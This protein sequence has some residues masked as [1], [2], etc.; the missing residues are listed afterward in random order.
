M[1]HIMKGILVNIILLR[2]HSFH[3]FN[4]TDDGNNLQEIK[5]YM[6]NLHIFSSNF[7]K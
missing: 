5:N 4:A 3:I 1:S 6:V 2:I 7:N